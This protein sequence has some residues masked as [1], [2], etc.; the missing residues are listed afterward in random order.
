[1]DSQYDIA[2]TEQFL[3]ICRQKFLVV[4]EFREAVSHK[5]FSMLSPALNNIHVL[6][7]I[8]MS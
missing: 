7:A 2:W 4:K 8:G 3:K 6:P 1:M 5:S